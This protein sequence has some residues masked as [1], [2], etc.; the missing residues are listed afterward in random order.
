MRRVRRPLSRTSRELASH[1]ARAPHRTGPVP[2]PVPVT[3]YTRVARG[4]AISAIRLGAGA[5]GPAGRTSI[6]S[7]HL[8]PMPDRGCAAGRCA[9]LCRARAAR[10][11]D[12]PDLPS[13]PH[14]AR[15][16]HLGLHA[17]PGGAPRAHEMNRDP[18]RRRTRVPERNL[19]WT[20]AV[21][22][23]VGRTG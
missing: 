8:G 22:R 10:T 16:A 9:A 1:D 3:A 12:E 7:G 5:A 15:A 4:A 13:A 17:Q 21:S 18:R 19:R 11:H 14:R 20:I 6:V 2:V 23:P